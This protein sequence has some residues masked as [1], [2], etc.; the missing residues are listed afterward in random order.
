ML[1]SSNKSS[2]L[3]LW[4]TNP[5]HVSPLQS[6]VGSFCLFLVPISCQGQGIVDT[7][8]SMSLHKHLE[9]SCR[10]EQQFLK[11]NQS[12]LV[13]PSSLDHVQHSKAPLLAR[14]ESTSHPSYSCSPQCNLPYET[15]RIWILFSFH[16]LLLLL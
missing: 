15:T 5:Y 14:C 8:S 12:N 10:H 3:K 4:L 2:I 13:R 6:L 9:R 11:L 16:E 1:N 7:S